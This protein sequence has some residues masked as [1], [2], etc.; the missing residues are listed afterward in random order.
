[1]FY[2]NQET[3]FI[4]ALC[5]FTFFWLSCFPPS[6]PVVFA[7]SNSIKQYKLVIR[8]PQLATIPDP[9][10]MDQKSPK[11]SSL[12][13]QIVHDL[14]LWIL[15]TTCVIRER[16]HFPSAIMDLHFVFAS[17]GSVVLQQ[18]IRLPLRT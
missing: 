18:R 1:M 4:L 9:D 12:A 5:S 11:N 6:F 3:V 17:L 16:Y 2:V 8:Y 10:Q 15:S 14:Y 13:L 7:I